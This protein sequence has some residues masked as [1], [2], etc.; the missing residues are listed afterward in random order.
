MQNYCSN[1]YCST[2]NLGQYLLSIVNL[3]AKEDKVLI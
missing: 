3:G 1:V 2:A